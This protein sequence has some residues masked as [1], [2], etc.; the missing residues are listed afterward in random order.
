MP[1]PQ[2]LAV[3]GLFFDNAAVWLPGGLTMEM[4]AALGDEYGLV[5]ATR[6]GSLL[7]L[8]DRLVTGS[9][10][11]YQIL[12]L[13]D[14]GPPCPH[15]VVEAGTC[16]VDGRTDQRVF[17]LMDQAY[18]CGGHGESTPLRAYRAERGHLVEIDPERVTCGSWSCESP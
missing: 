14:L 17:A 10:P 8:L 9:P 3:A 18:Q 2:R 13:I 6:N 15:L 12:D 5:A 11:T 16:E 4:E 7:V 1:P